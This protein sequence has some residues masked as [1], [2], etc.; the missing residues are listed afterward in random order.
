MRKIL[1]KKLVRISELKDEGFTAPFCINCKWVILEPKY[2]LLNEKNRFSAF[3]CSIECLVDWI[4]KEL[5]KKK[6]I[7]L[8]I[9]TL[10]EYLNEG[11]NKKR[12]RK[13]GNNNK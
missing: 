8:K 3:F 9:Y 11:K 1:S 7:F 4:K 12:R 2:V 6:K 5:K 10:K 13:N